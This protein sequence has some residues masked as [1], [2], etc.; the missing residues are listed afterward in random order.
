[1]ADDVLAVLRR[2]NPVEPESLEIPAT[3]ADRVL[4]LPDRG[5]RP[6]VVGPAVLAGAAGVVTAGVLLLVSMGG[7]SP[8][9]AERAMAAVQPRGIVHWH[10]VMTGY[11]NGVAK[12]RQDIEGWQRGRVT[13]VLH[14]D[15][16]HGKPHVTADVR[17]VG[18]HAL[19]WMSISDDYSA[20]TVS[21]QHEVD[22]IP[23]GDPL[24]SFRLAYRRHLLRDLGGGKFDVRYR[25]LPPRSVVYEV[26]PKTALPRRLVVTS[27][28]RWIPG[29]GRLVSTTVVTFAVYEH[30]ADSAANR[31]R[32]AL[33]PHPGAGPDNEQPY[34]HFAALRTGTP[35]TGARGRTLARFASEMPRYRLSIAGIR[36]VAPGVYLIPGR[37]YV[38]IAIASRI[39]VGGSCVT[40]KKAVER[41]VSVGTPHGSKF[42]TTIVV[43][44]GVASVKARQY[45][46]GHFRT[47]PA[48]HGIVHLPGLSY[49][50][51]LSRRP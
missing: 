29:Q 48:R 10:L 42:V 16:V 36:A 47:Y 8:D 49:Q 22:P 35:P 39:G 31:Q 44:D 6:R 37:G 14:S 2:V 38:C 41:G 25:H 32:L 15:V 12:S 13:H 1:M 33:L 30:L 18:R 34:D 4:S 5:A 43:P 40:V 11:V 21:S 23:S 46:R 7:S 27:G 20:G 28:T 9:L 45:W 3:L 50:W 51:L 24:A 19:T 17:I 26:D